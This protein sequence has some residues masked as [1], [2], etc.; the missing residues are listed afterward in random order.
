MEA[1]LIYLLIP[2]SLIFLAHWQLTKFEL[3][4]AQ[5][6]I[7]LLQKALSKKSRKMSEKE[8]PNGTM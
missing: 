1:S 7:I 3:K 8:D 4:K 6:H 5:D 2:L